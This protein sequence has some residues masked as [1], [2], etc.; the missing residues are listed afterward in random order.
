[1]DYM[2]SINPFQLITKLYS[3]EEIYEKDEKQNCL[4]K[5]P[6]ELLVIIFSHLD[7]IN[8]ESTVLVNKKWKHISIDIA[9]KKEFNLLQNF[10]QLLNKK[11]G[12]QICEGQ[13]KQILGIDNSKLLECRSLLEVES[14]VKEL[15]NSILDVL[16]LN[17]EDINDH[18]AFF[19][20]LA[21]VALLLINWD[22]FSS[23]SVDIAL[24]IIDL[25]DDDSIFCAAHIELALQLIDIGDSEGAIYTIDV[26]DE[27]SIFLKIITEVALKLAN[28][29]DVDTVLD[30]ADLIEKDITYSEILSKISLKV[31]ENCLIDLHED[32]K[33]EKINHVLEIANNISID[34][35]QSQTYSDI[36]LK[37]YNMCF[38]KILW[39]D[40]AIA[41]ASKI[42]INYI[43]SDTL[44]QIS[45]GLMIFDK[46]F[47]KAK[48]AAKEISSIIGRGK[49]FREIIQELAR[50]NLNQAVETMKELFSI[51]HM[52]GLEDLKFY[53]KHAWRDICQVLTEAGHIDKAK[54]IA[55]KITDP[56]LQWLVFGEILNKKFHNFE[57]KF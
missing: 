15:K 34:M 35:I 43:Q 48:E 57:I 9:R 1:M 5:L 26:I 54:E 38:N 11:L 21:E 37:L 24:D 27:D 44:S 47:S 19:E 56:G 18:S 28:R 52:T 3:T 7:V 55:S 4:E 46:D 20:T 33:P 36:S 29:G 10:V 25:I 51:S 17:E 45:L 41:V 39:I 22:C 14:S 8:M 42:S 12:N 49:A 50:V 6:D 53:E 13:R 32:D 40:K 23:S 2:Q 30:I 31:L 16:K